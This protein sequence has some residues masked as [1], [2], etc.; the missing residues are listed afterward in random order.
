LVEE[1]DQFKASRKSHPGKNFEVLSPKAVST[2]AEFTL[3]EGGQSFS[4]KAFN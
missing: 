1:I 2:L 3:F 4:V